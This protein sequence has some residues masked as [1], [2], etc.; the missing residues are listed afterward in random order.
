MKYFFLFLLVFFTNDA[1]ANYFKNIKPYIGIDMGLNFADY[2]YN[3]DLDD[4]YFSVST[5]AGL[6]LKK[7]LG[8]E[9]FF[10]QSST[11]KL[12]FISDNQAQNHEFYYQAIGFDLYGFYN[13]SKDFDFFTT[14]GVARYYTFNK[15]ECVG[16]KNYSD[17][18]SVKNTTSRFGI[19]F[20]YN[21]PYNNIHGIIRYNFSPINNDLIKNLSEISLGFK[22]VF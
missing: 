1:L 19:G 18:I 10:T 15:Y 20:I 17:K 16:L 6:R 11:N 22:Y 7:N 5:N 12:N 13:L 3:T 21:F 9:I 2:K 4:L 8:L 14:V